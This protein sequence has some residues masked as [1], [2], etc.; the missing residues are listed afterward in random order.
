MGVLRDRT[1]R[2]TTQWSKGKVKRVF[3]TGDKL[4][5]KNMIL[6]YS[7]LTILVE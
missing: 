4:E 3:F 6:E 2:V 5:Y 7:P 1:S